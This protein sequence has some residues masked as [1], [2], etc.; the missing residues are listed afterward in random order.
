M[1]A[2]TAAA[3]AA[4]AAAIAKR[5]LERRALGVFDCPFWPQQ[6]IARGG[7]GWLT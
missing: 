2:A 6:A 1:N 3:N 5:T 4:N 7:G